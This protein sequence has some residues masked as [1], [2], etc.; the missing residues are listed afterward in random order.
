[1]VLGALVDA[2][3]P[4]EVLRQALGSL[5][6]EGVTL[7]AERV[8]RAGV[9]A[10][11]CHVLVHG[12]RPDAGPERADAV[13]EGAAPAGDAHDT[14]HEDRHTHAH[15]HGHST[16]M[17]TSATPT[18]MATPTSTDT[19][20]VMNTTT[21]GDLPTTMGIGRLPTSRR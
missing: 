4:I 18:S 3:V 12:T 6:L 5:A 21:P 13:G 1:M 17:D 11:K 14:R 2:G 7:E 19:P 10:T 20:T 15:G 9:S 8:M 16:I